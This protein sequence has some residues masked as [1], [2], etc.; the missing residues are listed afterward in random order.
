MRTLL[1]SVVE[2]TDDSEVEKDYWEV[3]E[4]KTGLTWVKGLLAACLGRTSC[5][6]LFLPTFPSSWLLERRTSVLPCLSALSHHRH[7]DSG[8]NQQ[9]METSE[10]E[11]KQTSQVLITVTKSWVIQ[12]SACVA[13]NLGKSFTLRKQ[14]FAIKVSKWVIPQKSKKQNEMK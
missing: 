7:R 6:S 9:W 10:T 8:S 1:C 4:V 11:P 12:P 3:V 13:G 14:Q 5:T 2:S